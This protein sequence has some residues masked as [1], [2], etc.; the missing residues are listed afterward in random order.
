MQE[1]AEA[2][3]AINREYERQCRAA[4]AVAEAYFDAKQ[5]LRAILNVAL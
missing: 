3:A 1:G 4:R 5:V 2:L